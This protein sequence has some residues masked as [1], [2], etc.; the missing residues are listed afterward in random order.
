MIDS[1]VGSDYSLFLCDELIDQGVDVSLVMTEDRN[2]GVE[3]KVKIF[4]LMPSKSLHKSKVKKAF[5]F[6]KYLLRIVKLINKGKYDII[7]YQFFRLKSIECIFF[8]VLKFLNIKI[9]H[10]AH[11]VL[12]TNNYKLESIYDK[13]IYKLSDVLLVHSERN[14]N[15][16]IKYYRV[17]PEKVFVIPM[18]G[19]RFY[20]E[21]E[22]INTETARERLK[23]DLSKKV[24]LF[25]GAIK[26]YKGL[27]VLLRAINHYD[28]NDLVLIIAGAFDSKELEAEIISAIKNVNKNVQIITKFGYV[29]PSEIP[30]IFSASDIVV[31]PYKR[32]T[33]SGVV[34]LAYS[35]AKPVL[36]TKVGDFEDTIKHH[37]TG[38]LIEPN[39]DRELL[40]AIIQ[41]TS[42]SL[43]L[44]LMG[45][46][47]KEL[48]DREYSWAVCAGRLK[49]RYTSFINCGI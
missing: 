28:K 25:F 13:I 21:E 7:H 29:K 6:P 24:I 11:E 35:F 38:I 33:H 20:K 31:L 26:L 2:I 32:I 40:D 1:L 36:A 46:Y 30:I 10:T 17:A 49:E 22:E 3:S 44:K 18:G 4:R 43:D 5:Y 48:N 37:K 8:F 41:I 9:F 15:D 19:A 27:D 34:H 14:K 45:K 23:I 42:G 47:A 12:P 39:D 16:L